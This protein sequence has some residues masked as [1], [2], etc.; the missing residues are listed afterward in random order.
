LRAVD[1]RVEMAMIEAGSKLLM[2]EE[3]TAWMREKWSRE[4]SSSHGGNGK[5]RDKAPQKDSEP[6]NT[7]TC[8]RRGKTGHLAQNCK[9][10]KEEAHLIQVESE[11]PVTSWP[12]A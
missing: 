9:N 7:D 1:E 4:G 3:W 6:L 2:T 5:R 10:P 12:R 11:E 8:R